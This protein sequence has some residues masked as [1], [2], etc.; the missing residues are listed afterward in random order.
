MS[1]QNLDKLE[2]VTHVWVMILVT[3]VTLAFASLFFSMSYNIVHESNR[4]TTRIEQLRE[5]NKTI[6]DSY[7]HDSYKLTE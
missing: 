2:V 4:E 1:K 6:R 3:I 5:L 7:T